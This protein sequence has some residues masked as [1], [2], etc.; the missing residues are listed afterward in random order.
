[1]SRSRESMTARSVLHHRT[2]R[3]KPCHAP[4][5][6]HRETRRHACRD[7]HADA[8]LDARTDCVR[9]APV[10]APH[11]HSAF[12]KN[13]PTCPRQIPGLPRH[14][15]VGPNHP[16]TTSIRSHKTS[17]YAETPAD[18]SSVREISASG[19]S[20]HRNQSNISGGSEVVRKGLSSALHSMRP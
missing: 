6:P 20:S 18:R 4:V 10:S 13:R 5:Y 17:R 12:H 15:S 1:M 2:C 8:Y 11:P 19:L 16:S 3:R 7:H 14:H 9:H